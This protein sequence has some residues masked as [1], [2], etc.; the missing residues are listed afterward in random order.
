MKVNSD[1]GEEYISM[2]TLTQATPSHTT[3][4]LEQSRNTKN[5]VVKTY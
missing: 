1:C 2:S 3:P 5:N 4:K